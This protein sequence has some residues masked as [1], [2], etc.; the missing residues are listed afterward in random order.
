MVAEGGANSKEKQID[1][2]CENNLNVMILELVSDC[3]LSTKMARGTEE[4]KG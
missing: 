4:T 1:V 2:S 3:V